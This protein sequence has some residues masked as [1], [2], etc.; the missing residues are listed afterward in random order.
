MDG[1][2]GERMVVKPWVESGMRMC[3]GKEVGP[4]WGK[5]GSEKDGNEGAV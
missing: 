2:V 1:W 4:V 3:K 5:R